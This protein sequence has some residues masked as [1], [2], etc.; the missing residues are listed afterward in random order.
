MTADWAPARQVIAYQ[1]PDDPPGLLPAAWYVP[2]RELQV[3]RRHRLLG[4]SL[5]VMAVG[6][7]VA[8]P[9]A[10]A[11]AVTAGLIVLRAADRI[12]VSLEARRYARGP[13]A[14]DPLLV[15]A[16]TPWML[17]TAV[18]VTLLL[19]PLLLMAATAIAAAG[20]AM[21]GRHLALAAA[22]AAVYTV[23][24]C[25]GP[26]SRAPRRELNRFLNAITR[27]R[28]DPGQARPRAEM[29][30]LALPAGPYRDG[31]DLAGPRLAVTGPP[32]PAAAVRPRRR[33]FR[34]TKRFLGTVTALAA[35]GAI[36]FTGLLLVLPG[37]GDA[38]SVA[39]ALD[40]A[41]HTGYPGPALPPR[42][43]AS[44]VATEDHRFYSEPGIDPAAIGRVIL[45]RFT[46]GPDQG[47]ATLYQQLARMLYVGGQSG[48]LAE[49]EQILLG[50]KLDLN[51]SKAQILRMYAGVAYF[52]HGYYGLA[53]ASCGYF[54]EQPAELS[55]GQAAMLA[56]LVQAPSADDPYSHFANARAREAHVLV[57]LIAMRQLT[58]AQATQAYWLPVYLA[59][60]VS[61]DARS[62]SCVTHSR[63]LPAVVGLAA[64]DL[65]DQNVLWGWRVGV[66]DS[67]QGSL[68][69][70]LGDDLVL[71]VRAWLVRYHCDFPGDE[72]GIGILPEPGQQALRG[73]LEPGLERCGGQAD[74]TQNS[75][76]GLDERGTGAL[77][78]QGNHRDHQGQAD[79][80]RDQL[81]PQRPQHA[82][83]GT[84]SS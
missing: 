11:I 33:R 35:L 38:P 78:D 63:S 43:A 83:G 31:E 76:Q 59:R 72:V 70:L 37:V 22:V 14:W 82:K 23:L 7:S 36:V 58:P 84:P 28:P 45:G 32:R 30:A 48:M 71:S 44:L 2:A 47:G 67:G 53:A 26:G 17:V 55:W 69:E 54:A 41:H 20:I 39:Q 34:Q 49:A 60:G 68:A 27:T 61:A 4:F 51:Y 57:R 64:G 6:I 21:G 25:V 50:I 74:S 13:R 8:V 40:R 81:G 75:Q 1:E 77:G 29:T 19:A 3:P 10:G 79:G 65:V 46:K 18:G 73:D 12:T 15:A 56:G 9:V 66:C 52:G 80:R 62:A 16:N 5:M 42:M 24:S